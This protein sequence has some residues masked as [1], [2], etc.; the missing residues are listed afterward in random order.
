MTDSSIDNGNGSECSSALGIDNFS[1]LALIG[2]FWVKI[3]V[4]KLNIYFTCKTHAQKS[5]NVVLLCGHRKPSG[6]PLALEYV[7]ILIGH[8]SVNCCKCG[9]H[10]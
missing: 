4:D 7:G 6:H 8:L 9:Q 3:F 5:G 1:V 2:V 10:R